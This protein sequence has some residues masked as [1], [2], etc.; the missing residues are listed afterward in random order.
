[1]DILIILE[2]EDDLINYI[3]YEKNPTFYYIFI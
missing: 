2:M 1:M 3:I